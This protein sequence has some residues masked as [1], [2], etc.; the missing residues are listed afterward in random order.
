ML[1][2]CDVITIHFSPLD[3]TQKPGTYF[4]KP[5]RR[6]SLQSKGQEYVPVK[7]IGSGARLPWIQSQLYHFSAVTMANY[8]ST[9]SEGCYEGSMNNKRQVLGTAFAI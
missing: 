9:F 4:W 3:Q 5:S 7:I 6:M 1:D 2:S 8:S